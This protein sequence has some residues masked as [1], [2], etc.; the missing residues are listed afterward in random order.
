MSPGWALG[1]SSLVSPCTF[2]AP[3]RSLAWC[4]AVAAGQCVRVCL[5]A[6]GHGRLALLGFFQHVSLLC[7]AP[8]GAV[9]TGGVL[10]GGLIAFK[11]G[12]SALSQQ[13][14]RARVIVQGITV[15]IMVGSGG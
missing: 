11:N 15:A 10:L 9:A 3:L 2:F 6:H 8:L 1:L 7:V 13:F 14:M 4:T 5:A 12:K